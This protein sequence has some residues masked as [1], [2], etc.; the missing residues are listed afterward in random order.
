MHAYDGDQ[1]TAYVDAGGYLLESSFQ[2]PVSHAIS[3]PGWFGAH[4]DRM[5]DYTRYASCG[6]VVGTDHNGRVKRTALLRE[7][8]GPIDY[9]MTDADLDVLKRGMTTA[10]Q[11]YLA[12]GADLV[13]PSTFTDAP[14][15]AAE[16]GAG[17]RA[18]RSAPTW[19]ARSARPPTSR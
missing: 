15:S 19:T 16:F 18:T 13:L 7:L 3:V 6:V 12:A 1:M 9:R 2:P 10:A 11:V 5:R 8:L 4:F 14:I 17:R